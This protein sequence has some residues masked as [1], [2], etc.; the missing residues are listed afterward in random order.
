MERKVILVTGASRGIGRAI[1]KELAEEGHKVI[2]NYNKSKEKAEELK[3]EL[4]QNG[5]ELDIYKADVSKREEVS[6]MV[7]Y[8]LEKYSSYILKYNI[9]CDIK[10]MSWKNIIKIWGA[11][12]K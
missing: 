1:A 7:S 5:I 10:E 9:S 2:A 8:V 3:A 4:K 6:Q 12:E 11:N